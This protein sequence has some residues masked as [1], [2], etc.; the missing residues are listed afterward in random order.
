VVRANRSLTVA[1]AVTFAG[2]AACQERQPLPTKVLAE[3]SYG[4]SGGVTGGGSTTTWLPDGSIKTCATK[5][6]RD[7]PSCTT[8]PGDVAA[9][10]RLQL[11]LD[12]ADF[13]RLP[14]GSPS[15][16]TCTLRRGAKSVF[17]GPQTERVL[18]P[19]LQLLRASRTK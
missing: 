1:L 11:A 2:G 10:T 15:N 12:Q 13:D 7:A 8:V 6:Y 16:Y 14:E 3:V 5:T 9:F 18:E 17:I 19:A 4:C